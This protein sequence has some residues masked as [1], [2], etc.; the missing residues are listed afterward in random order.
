MASVSSCP[1]LA[2]FEMID[3]KTQI[4]YTFSSYLSI[5]LL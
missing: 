5:V 2:F 4:A 3:R 1:F